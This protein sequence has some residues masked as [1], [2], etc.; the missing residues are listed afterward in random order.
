MLQY[1]VENQV[2]DTAVASSLVFMNCVVT[3]LKRLICVVNDFDGVSK[4]LEVRLII[5]SERVIKLASGRL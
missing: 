2:I 1:L 3:V 4:K 5:A